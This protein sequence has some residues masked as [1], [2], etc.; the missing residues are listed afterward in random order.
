M[1]RDRTGLNRELVGLAPKLRRYAYALTRNAED[2]DDLL[3]TTLERLLSRPIPEDAVIEKWAVRVCR[4]IWFDEMR[5]RRVRREAAGELAREDDGAPSTERAA[6]ARIELARVE[7]G[8]DALPDEQREVL[9]LV[10]IG[11]MAYREAADALAVP[12]GTVMSRLARAR[13]ALAAHMEAPT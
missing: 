11:G 4:N 8:I 3:Q 2:A 10:V 7:Q 1:T 6:L 9:A 5:S 12:I 13:S